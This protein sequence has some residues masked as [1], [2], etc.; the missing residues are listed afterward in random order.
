MEPEDQEAE[1]YFAALAG[2]GR[3]APGPAALREALLAQK[4]VIDEAESATMA[5]LDEAE[6]LK[7]DGIKRRLEAAGAWKRRDAVRAPPPPAS[8]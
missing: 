2:R 7:M 3:G 6:R 4:K 1:N 5:D 8:W